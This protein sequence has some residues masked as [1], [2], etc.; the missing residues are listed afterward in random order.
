MYEIELTEDAERH[1]DDFSSRDRAVLLATIEEQLT[2]QP[3]VPT[4]NRKL[5]REN[6]LAR[7][8]PRVQKFRVFYNIDE[9]NHTGVITAIGIKEGNRFR[10]DGKEYPL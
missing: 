6:P 8:E 1:V 3:G 7:W 5:M 2:H 4:K 9:P 10:I